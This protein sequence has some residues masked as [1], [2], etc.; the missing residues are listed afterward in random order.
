MVVHSLWVTHGIGIQTLTDPCLVLDTGPA[1][2]GD[3]SAGEQE[4]DRCRGHR[5]GFLHLVAA[6]A[7]YQ[8]VIQPLHDCTTATDLMYRRR[9]S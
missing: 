7:G 9:G 3:D 6:W 1:L 4:P 2:T 5:S 8:R